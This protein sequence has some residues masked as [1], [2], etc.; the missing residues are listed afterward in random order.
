MDS[1]A[2]EPL[3]IGISFPVSQ[4]SLA[5]EIDHFPPDVWERV[6]KMC[7]VKQDLVQ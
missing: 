7:Q 5:I 2:L 3:T 1:V 4:C 6:G